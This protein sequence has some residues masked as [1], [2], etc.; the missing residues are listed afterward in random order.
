[1]K[2]TWF[3]EYYDE[4]KDEWIPWMNYISRAHARTSLIN[5][6]DNKPHYRVRKY[7]MEEKCVK[8]R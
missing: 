2:H 3:I 4:D 6:Y 7:V 5:E 8:S 1:M